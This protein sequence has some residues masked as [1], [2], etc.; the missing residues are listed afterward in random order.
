[1]GYRNRIVMGLDEAI[2]KLTQAREMMTG[3]AFPEEFDTSQFLV[4]CAEASGNV[5]F[6]LHE[7]GECMVAREPKAD[8]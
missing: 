2:A 4:T 1:M 7:A 8:K 6:V 3:D 5:T